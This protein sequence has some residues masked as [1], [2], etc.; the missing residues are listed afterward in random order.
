MVDVADNVGFFG[1]VAQSARIVVERWKRSPSTELQPLRSNP[2][3]LLV[4]SLIVTATCLFLFALDQS[5]S[6]SARSLPDPVI[7]FFKVFT[8]LGQSA[9]FILVSGVASL[10]LAATPWRQ[11]PRR[12]R[13]QRAH[14]HADTTFFFAVILT[15]GIL[16]RV[17]KDIIGRARPNN[18]LSEGPLHFEF[19]AW[20]PQFASFPSGH[21]TTFGAACMLF[22]FYTPKWRPALLA[23]ALAGGASRVIVGWHYPADV[24][25]GLAFGA[26]LA[27]VAARYMARR[28]VMFIVPPGKILPIRSRL[29]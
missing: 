28:G 2:P 6:D 13:V 8:E 19:F 21:A 7:S 24:I 5:V 3:F 22:A 16:S 1:R 4:A 27:L 12:Q 25:A 20:S 17:I 26:G 10:F 18:S 23:L 29:R 9:W 14:L 15:S 11:L